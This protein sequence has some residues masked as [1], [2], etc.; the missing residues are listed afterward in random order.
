M[1]GRSLMAR[2]ACSIVT[3]A[4]ATAAMAPGASAAQVVISPRQGARI[5]ANTVRIAVRAGNDWDDVTATLNG[6]QIGGAF[7]R[8]GGDMRALVA[9]ASYGLRLGANVLHV[10]AVQGLTVRRATIRFRV[11][12]RLP[13]IGAGRKLSVP[14]GSSIDLGGT[15]RP[16]AIRLGKR[17]GSAVRVRWRLVSVPTGSRFGRHKQASVPLTPIGPPLR[18]VTVP[19]KSLGSSQAPST[20]FRPDALGPYEIRLAATVGGRTVTDTVVLD[21]VPRNPVLTVDTASSANGVPGIQ[22]GA[23]VFPAPP[24]AHDQAGAARWSGVT[25]GGLDYHALWQLVAVDRATLDEIWNRTYGVCVPVGTHNASFCRISPNGDPVPVNVQQQIGSLG[26][27]RIVIASSHPAGSGPTGSDYWGAPNE[28]NFATD[29]LGLIGYPSNASVLTG[30]GAG[31]AAAIGVPGMSAGQADITVVPGGQGAMHGYLTPDTNSNFGFVPSARLAF[32]TRASSSCDASGCTV[33]QTFGDQTA[34]GTIP[35][36]QGGYLVAAYDAHTL[37]RR[38]EETFVTTS[39]SAGDPHTLGMARFLNQAGAAGEIVAITSIRTPGLGSKPMPDPRAAAAAWKRLAA[40]VA[41]VGGTRNTFNL[42]AASGTALYTL[43]G[44]SGAK[45]SNGVETSGSTARIR[46]AMM[47]NDRSLFRPVDVSAAGPPA[48]LLEQLVVRKPVTTWPLDDDPGAHAALDW[49]GSQFHTLGSSPRTAYWSEDIDPTTATRLSDEIGQLNYESGHGFTQSDFTAA[50]GELM[51]ELKWVGKVRDYLSKL[52]APQDQAGQQAWEDAKNLNDDLTSQLNNLDQKAELEFSWLD[53]AGSILDVTGGF[54]GL[55]KKAEKFANFVFAFAG[56]TELTGSILDDKWTGSPD[57][58]D[59]TVQA[60]QIGEKIQLQAQAKIAA[61]QRIGNMIVSD[62][63]KL[64]ELGTYAEC[65]EAQGECGTDNR[66]A[67]W[68]LP[69]GAQQDAGY[70]ATIAIDRVLYE[71]IVPLSFPVW[72]TG[73]FPDPDTSHFSCVNP[74]DDPFYGS[75]GMAQT[76]T[77]QALDPAAPGAKKVGTFNSWDTY[78]TVARSGLAYGW[79][80]GPVLSRMY[81]PV[82]TLLPAEKSG[83]GLS[84]QDLLPFSTSVYEP[85]GLVDCGWS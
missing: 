31:T 26:V 46:G 83:L 33:T 52:A 53:L 16:G 47:P 85:G 19:L 54:S 81:D 59:T 79:P 41:A 63:T 69:Q 36:G 38:A 73:T 70:A 45:E 25:A 12:R 43:I 30:A 23:R 48:D 82:D 51:K 58:A 1:V 22:L 37:A 34:T 50:Q 42:S 62:P 2:T 35:S 40:E 64:K 55:A 27:G 84:P 6:S 57:S 21:A 13:M 65:D 7:T 76:S 3:A 60:D 20:S 75:P 80:S 4:I 15:I 56:V 39:D 5:T 29:E 10:T 14:I 74:E 32:D 28:E 66:Y 78:L 67:Q 44:W 49:I 68:T 9:S 72:N 77:L 24:M 11:S 71:K 18:S 61:F 8:P 17:R